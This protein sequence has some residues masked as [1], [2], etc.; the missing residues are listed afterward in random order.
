[1]TAEARGLKL[2][3]DHPWIRLQARVLLRR[4]GVESREERT[5]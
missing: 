2:T 5:A 4:L 1:M 3:K